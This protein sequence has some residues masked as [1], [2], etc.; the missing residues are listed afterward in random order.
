MAQQ[1]IWIGEVVK[2]FERRAVEI[3]LEEWERWLEKPIPKNYLRS[4][5]V[6]QRL[7]DKGWNVPDYDLDTLWKKLKAMEQ[8]RGTGFIGRTQ[9][10][11]H[12]NWQFRWVNPDILEDTQELTGDSDYWSV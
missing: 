12:G 6:Y 8:I 7:V 5:P 4:E 10:A 1:V 3:L 2:T 11:K 9:W